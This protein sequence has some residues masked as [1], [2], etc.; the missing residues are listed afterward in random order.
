LKDDDLKALITVLRHIYNLPVA[1]DPADDWRAWLDIRINADKYLEPKLSKVADAKYREAALAYTDTDGIFDI[2]D[3][4]RTE[5]DY[6]QSLVAFG[7]G[8]RKNQSWQAPPECS[9][10]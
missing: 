1:P 8:I 9:F 6:D 2:I 7:E 3:T 10:S 5:M 4:I